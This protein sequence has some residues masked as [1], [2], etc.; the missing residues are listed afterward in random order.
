VS[1]HDQIGQKQVIEDYVRSVV[2]SNSE[3]T[4][5][6]WRT[7]DKEYVIEKLSERANGM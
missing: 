2:Y 3:Q 1:L 5:R 7:E 4:I 6:R